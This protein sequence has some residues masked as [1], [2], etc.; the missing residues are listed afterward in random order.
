MKNMGVGPFAGRP[1]GE[2]G[3]PAPAQ[4]APVEP[5]LTP[6]PRSAGPES[7]VE[8]QL[9]DALLAVAPRARERDLFARLGLAEAA[10]RDDV[11]K[12]FL[13][14]ARQFHPDRFAAPA[15]ADLQDV[16]RDFFAAV[17]EA[18]EVLSDDRK[19]AAYLAKRKGGDSA[20]SEGAKVDAQKGE[21]CLRTR[22]FARARGFLESAVRADTRPQYQAL[23][24]WA[25]VADHACKERERP[26]A[27]VAEAM[28][29]PSCDRAFYVAG[30]LARDDGDEAAA[31]RHLRAAVHANPR[32]ADA[33]RELR[34]MEG[35]RADK[36]R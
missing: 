7:S 14:L 10:G 16:V 20:R 25:Y 1:A 26:R 18:Y 13:A 8:A 34:L 30:I 4:P 9:R 21:A 32:N 23:L 33:V 31:E 36:R 11:K 2:G 12:A 35:R 5:R 17:N 27:L 3:R 19:R 15:L 22:D 28:K 24:A 29:D 6:P